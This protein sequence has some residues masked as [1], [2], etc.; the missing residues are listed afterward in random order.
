MQRSIIIVVAIII[1]L[2][3]GFLFGYE[4]RV[5]NWF[6]KNNTNNT[7]TVPMSV[8]SVNL[9]D[10]FFNIKAEYPQF[11]IRGV[12]ALN[13]KISDLIDNKIASFKKDSQDNWN[14]RRATA[15]PDNP[16]PENPEQPFDF[17]ATW[18]P[19][20]INDQY[21]SFYI[22]IYNFTGG[23]HGAGEIDTFNYDIK[24]K[25]EITIMDFLG[26]SQ[27]SLQNLSVLAAQNVGYDLQ[28]KGMPMNDFLNQMIADGTAPK[29]DNYSNFN[30][31][32]NSLTIYFQQYQVAPGSA[33]QI[34]ITLYKQ[35]L[36]QNSIKSEYLQ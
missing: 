36:E 3:L 22:N 13:K 32:H 14:A 6:T 5:G 4:I 28:S 20:Q 33:G 8:N 30:F 26:N 21:L 18:T 25:K 16:V 29:I 31:N 12:D 24:N 35:E 2:A 1:L 11:Q 9:L 19:T 7:S 23:A 34:T 10:S 27:D 15:T 17:I